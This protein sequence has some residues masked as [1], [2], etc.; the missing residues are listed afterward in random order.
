M[1]LTR[2][3]LLDAMRS[4]RYAVQCSVGPGGAPQSAIVGVAVSDDFDV[5]FDALGTSRKAQ[6]LRSRPEIALVFGSL[7]GSDERTVQFEGIADEPTGADRD[8]LV[9]LYLTVF[10]DG[11]ER[12][13][14]PHLTYL[15]ARPRW[16][17]YSDFNVNPPEIVE[18]ERDSLLRL[19]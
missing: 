15:R 2:G 16:L 10:P 4:R 17:R 14:W 18:L 11:R 5:V 6:N 9:D 8:R 19:V 13:S 3:S 7:E 12:Q 1:S